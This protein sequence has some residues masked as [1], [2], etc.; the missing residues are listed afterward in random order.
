[1]SFLELYLKS[2]EK[3]IVERVSR[4]KEQPYK[5]EALEFIQLIK[6]D[7]LHHDPTLTQKKL[8]KILDLVPIQLYHMCIRNFG[9]T[10]TR[11]INRCRVEE[12]KTLLSRPPHE[13][14]E[15]DELIYLAGFGSQASFYLNFRRFEK[16][17][18]TEFQ[19][20]HMNFKEK[21]GM[22]LVEYQGKA[23]N[24]V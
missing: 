7:R 2:S 11:V 17:T 9:I 21:T 20:F 12:A 15:F 22:N 18:P 6:N 19:M 13:E 23:D 1:M 16:M 8:C 3:Y 14:I 24:I 10:Y 4:G 5:K